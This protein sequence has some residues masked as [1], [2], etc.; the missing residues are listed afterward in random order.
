MAVKKP[1]GQPG[2]LFRR[3]LVFPT[4]LFSAAQLEMLRRTDSVEVMKALIWAHWF[5]VVALV[6][7]YT[8]FATVQDIIAIIKTGR[9]LPYKDE[10]GSTTTKI[11]QTVVTP[12]PTVA[13]ADPA[14]PSGKI[15][16][17]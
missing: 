16:G 14:T 4:V 7:M 2:W 12:S 8:G 11:E 5:I 1:E 15:E 9:G 17:L 3:W 10:P 6:F 13:G